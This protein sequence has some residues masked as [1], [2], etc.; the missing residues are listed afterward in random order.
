MKSLY[1]TV[2]STEENTL[3]IYSAAWFMKML[4]WLPRSDLKC[5]GK[6]D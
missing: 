6:I 4:A 1:I 2:E 3:S 5:S